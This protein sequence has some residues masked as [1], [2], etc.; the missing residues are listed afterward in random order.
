MFSLGAYIGFYSMHGYP[1]TSE[2]VA[3]PSCLK[4]ADM[5]IYEA[6]LC[7]GLDPL[8][9]AVVDLSRIID[10]GDMLRVGPSGP[11]QDIGEVEGGENELNEIMD[12]FF[13]RNA[14]RRGPKAENAVILSEE[15]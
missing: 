4:G 13:A 7:L 14:K 11:V 15:I 1:H 8:V 3:L 6:L 12:W 2:T 5:A 10:E 9:K